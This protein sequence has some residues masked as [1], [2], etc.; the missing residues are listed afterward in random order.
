MGF[1]TRA[2][3]GRRAGEGRIM[4]LPWSVTSGAW[5]M[6]WNLGMDRLQLEIQHM[7]GKSNSHKS[8]NT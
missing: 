6:G 5:P 8:R 1:A 3:S 2:G 7:K 4:S